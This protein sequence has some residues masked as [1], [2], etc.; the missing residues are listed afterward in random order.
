MSMNPFNL[1]TKGHTIRGTKDLGHYKLL[2]KNPLPNFSANKGAKANPTTS[3]VVR[4]AKQAALFEQAKPAHLPA[5]ALPKPE[6]V[7][8]PEPRVVHAV[9]AIPPMPAPKAPSAATTIA[10]APAKPAV[11][12]KW[13]DAAA[14]WM[15]Q[16][17]PG[18]KP[19]PMP[20]MAVQTELA[21]EKVKVIRNDLAEDDLEV[22]AVN[23]KAGKEAKPARDA[24][25]LQVQEQQ[26]ASAQP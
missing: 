26:Q 15:R 20:A 25:A 2:T 18:R 22:V 8:K 10:E 13:A 12:S 11:W 3:H 17:A 6:A 9:R 24:K 21:L 1:M 7:A 19:S 14:G 5:P 16:L 23:A 4:E